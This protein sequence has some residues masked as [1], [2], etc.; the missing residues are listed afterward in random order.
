M[1]L[2]LINIS[3][4]SLLYILI[5]IPIISTQDLIEKNQTRFLEQFSAQRFPDH[6]TVY[7][8]LKI[9]NNHYTPNIFT[10]KPHNFQL[11]MK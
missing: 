10:V 5:S 6:H 9:Q 8:E 1:G 7:I 3:D 11:L 4:Q 2:L